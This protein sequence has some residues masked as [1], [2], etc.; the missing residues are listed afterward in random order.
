MLAYL[1]YLNLFS[2][3]NLIDILFE[4]LEGR[5][6]R[7]GRP[8]DMV[9]I[10]FKRAKRPQ[11]KSQRQTSMLY[12]HQSEQQRQQPPFHNLPPYD[13]YM[14]GK[15]VNLSNHHI[16]LPSVSHQFE[17]PRCLSSNY[18]DLD[19]LY[20]QTNTRGNCEYIS[21]VK[22]NK[23][24]SLDMDYS[25]NYVD[26]CDNDHG[27]YTTNYNNGGATVWRGSACNCINIATC[28]RENLS[29]FLHSKDCVFFMHQQQ[30]QHRRIM[31]QANVQHVNYYMMMN[32]EP[33]YV[34]LKSFSHSDYNLTRGNVN[35]KLV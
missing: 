21:A 13:N 18:N 5:P 30:Q 3:E 29:E 7:P 16:Y 31:G 19:D 15:L 11:S 12:I 4:Y 32:E 20:Q 26:K 25:F 23:N 22:D 9:P 33:N 14:S 28:S 2:N 10:E 1:V 6:S 8:Y 34:K 24:V 17:Q 27:N 35:V